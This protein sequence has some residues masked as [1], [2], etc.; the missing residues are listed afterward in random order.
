MA[1]YREKIDEK[2]M[3][4]DVDGRQP[5][6]QMIGRRLAVNSTVVMQRLEMSVDRW[7]LARTVAQTAG[8]TMMIEV[9]TDRAGQRYEP[10]E[11]R[12]DGAVP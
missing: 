6:K 7:L 9:G 8:L 4:L 2:E 5:E 12:Y 11:F 3:T 1:L 10:A